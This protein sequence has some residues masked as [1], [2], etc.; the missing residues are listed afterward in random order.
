MKKYIQWI[1]PILL[2][3]IALFPLAA[4]FVPGLPHGHDAQDHVVRIANFY[5][6]LTEGVI[7]PRWGGNLNWGYG[8]PVM[9]FLYPCSSYI[10]SFFHFVG[11]SFVDA[12]KAV[13]VVAYIGSILTMYLWMNAA[14]GRR[15]GII[16]AL[17]YG[18]A[19]YRFVDIYVRMAIGEHMAFV[20][21]PLIM[22]FLYKLATSIVSPKNQELRTRNYMLGL[23]VSFALLVL[24]HNAIALMFI[25]IIGLYG[26]YLFF[27]EAKKNFLFFVYCFM[28]FGLGFGLSAFFWIPGFIEGKYTLRNIVT[29]GEALQ[30]FVPFTAFFYSPWDYGGNTTLTKEVGIAQWLGFLISCIVFIKTKDKHMRILLLVSGLSFFVSLF[31]MTGASWWIWKQMMILQN[32]QFP[33][34]FLSTTVF[35]TAVIGG[36]AIPYISRN[37][38]LRTK[39]LVFFV[40]CLV[41]IVSTIHMWHPK[42][43]QREPESFYTRVYPG[44]TDT[45]E[46]TPIWTTR[47]QE[48]YPKAPM[49]LISGEARI[50]PGKRTT[51]IHEYTIEA[52]TRA[53]LMEN[54]LYFPGWTVLV[55]GVVIEPEFQSGLHRGIMTFWVSEGVHSVS[56]EFR[57]TKIRRIAQYIS[58]GSVVLSLVSIGF[59]SI[60]KKRT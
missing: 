57:D 32:F 42:D 28:S 38:E 52:S 16:G 45:G 36:I 60:W 37:Y 34:R 20:F 15:A 50:T 14:W 1:A 39:N 22:Y 58:I 49:E 44:T 2:V 17:L 31:I 12:T 55:D 27:T 59:Y 3:F 40:F 46:S 23:G 4:F 35:I 54:T 25:P 21:P 48:E 43:Y 29:A 26:L 13:F 8:H 19:P 47:F 18:F 11:L 24:S 6:A 41:P 53:E 30:R 7:F 9:M 56:V 5:K 10:A 33:V 51:T